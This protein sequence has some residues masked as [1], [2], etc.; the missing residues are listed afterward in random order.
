MRVGRSGGKWEQSLRG[1]SEIDLSFFTLGTLP[2]VVRRGERD[3]VLEG[4]HHLEFHFTFTRLPQAWC[5]LPSHNL[6]EINLMCKFYISP[7][8]SKGAF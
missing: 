6:P 7:Q 4:I 1:N 5:S 2:V 3:R 8:S